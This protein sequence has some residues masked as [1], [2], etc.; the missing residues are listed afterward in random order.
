MGEFSMA[1]REDV[2]YVRSLLDDYYPHSFARGVAAGDS[3][4][5][6]VPPEMQVGAIDDEG[7][8]QWKILEPVIT[9]DDVTGLESEFGILLP[10][11]FRAYL[12][13]GCHLFDQVRSSLYD[14]Q[15]LMPHVPSN[16]ALGPMKFTLVHWRPLIAAGYIPFAQWG[17][18]WG[19]MCFDDQQRADGDCP[20]VWMDHELIIPLGEEQCQNREL[21]A[22]H[23]RPLYSDSMAFL[24]DVFSVV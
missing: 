9:L 5:V 20:I 21:I 22:P 15:I 16:N 1:L 2:K 14:Q 4:G 6:G 18:G 17:D 12:L 7:W 10:D 24:R 8:V 23:A 19:P 11:P 3:D 13:A